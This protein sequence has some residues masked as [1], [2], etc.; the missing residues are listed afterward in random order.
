MNDRKDKKYSQTP[1]CQRES[2]KAN[3]SVFDSLFVFLLVE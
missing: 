3:L 1:D 2:N